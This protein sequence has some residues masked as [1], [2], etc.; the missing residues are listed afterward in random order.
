MV[1]TAPPARFT[2]T[3]RLRDGLIVS[4]CLLSGGAYLLYVRLGLHHSGFPLDDAWIYQVYARNLAQTGQWAF[5]PGTPSTGSTSIL[6]TLLIA[7]AYVFRVDAQFWTYLLGLLAL[8]AAALGAARLFD[9]ISLPVSLAAGLAVGL[10]WHLVWAAVSGMETMLFA[11]LLVWFWVWLRRS[12]PAQRRHFWRNGLALGTWGGILTLTRPEGV[13]AAGVGGL[14]GLV[15]SGRLGPKSLWSVAAALGYALPMLPFFYLNLSTS[16]TL[17]P[18]TFYAKQ[19]EYAVLWSIPYP[20]RLGDQL[21]QGWIGAQVLLL[22]GALADLWGRI[23]RRP[24][25]WLGLLPW[26]WLILHVALY[27]A[28]LPVIYQHG[29]YAIPVIPII[30]IYGIRGMASLTRPSSRQSLIRIGSLAWIAT[31]AVL[32]PAWLVVGAPAYAN[33]VAFIDVEMVATARWVQANTRADDVIAVHDIGA[34]GYY[35][36]HRI[37]DLA[38][39]VS[40][41]VI[42]FLTDGQRLSDYIVRQKASYLVVFPG[43]PGYEHLVA[44]PGFCKVW[45]ADQSPGYAA[46][47][48]DLGPMTVYRVAPGQPCQ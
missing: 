30:V 1:P 12:N 28:R 42:P 17:W 2:L 18:N 14:Y 16:A 38:G 7:P 19:T 33:D 31:T 5:V 20:I 23:R 48:P 47:A 13:L 22:P 40:P 39:L 43:W 15:S 27:A 25:D 32:F 9:D 37:V 6:W 10:E 34:L 21:V 4:M 36:P 24:A 35:A 41:A 45:S 46:Y 29:R 3:T 44:Y 8:V 26:L 11:A